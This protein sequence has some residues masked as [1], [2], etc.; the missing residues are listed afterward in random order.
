MSLRKQPIIFVDID[1]VL[2]TW[3]ELKRQTRT[4]GTNNHSQWS[5]QACKH[6]ANLCLRFDAEIVVSSS[7][8]HSHPLEQLKAV[9]RANGIHPSLVIGATPAVDE[10]EEVWN[11]DRAYYD[12]YCRGHEI[13]EWIL[14]NNPDCN[15]LIIDDDKDFLEHQLSR[16]VHVDAE[17]GFADK[18]AFNQA[19]TILNH[20]CKLKA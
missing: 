13:E 11:S 17:F 4:T 9:F 1:G 5:P 7:W 6:L 2:N 19:I 8:R 18:Q 3:D 15:Y 10:L 12:T 16:F 20:E 14:L